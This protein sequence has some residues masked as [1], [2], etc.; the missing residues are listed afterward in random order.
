VSTCCQQQ[1]SDSQDDG[2]NFQGEQGPVCYV[3][4]VM[5]FNF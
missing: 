5:L 3:D 1:V 4:R 2:N